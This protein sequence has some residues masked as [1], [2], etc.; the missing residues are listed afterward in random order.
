LRRW[1]NS[2]Q[3]QKA[4]SIENLKN[5]LVFSFVIL[6]ASQSMACELAE[7]THRLEVKKDTDGVYEDLLRCEIKG[8]LDGRLYWMLSNLNY[9][10]E[11]QVKKY[12]DLDLPLNLDYVCEAALRGY[13]LGVMEVSGLIGGPLPI[14]P[15]QEHYE[16]ANCLDN[17]LL[18]TDKTYVDTKMVKECLDLGFRKKNLNACF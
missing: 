3:G 4:M 8:E 5:S 2:E 17:I 14:F 15:I 18:V 16:V 10:R 13:R 12:A 9:G 11:E 1:L 7:L 6:I